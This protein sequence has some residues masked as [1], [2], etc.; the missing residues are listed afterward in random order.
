ME[1]QT[2]DVKEEAQV[3]DISGEVSEAGVSEVSSGSENTNEVENKTGNAEKSQSEEKSGQK[4]RYVPLSELQKERQRRRD[5]ERRLEKVES[6][7]KKS[8]EPNT[9]KEIME[10]LGVEEDVARKLHKHGLGKSSESTAKISE[11]D[12][13]RADFMDDANELIQSYDDWEEHRTDMEKV[14][15]EES[16]RSEE[17]ALRKGPEYYYLKAKLLRGQRKSESSV[18]DA[19]DKANGKTLASTENGRSSN[20]K[21]DDR[22]K[23]GTRAWLKSLS[24]EDFRKNHEYINSELSRGGFKN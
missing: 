5:L 11:A 10:D 23:K 24:P 21:G 13:L 9:I 20:P 3:Q 4:D 12:R 19:I 18:K 22:P 1:D 14:F 2:G 15:Q 7:V 16:S 8:S 6:D 17:S